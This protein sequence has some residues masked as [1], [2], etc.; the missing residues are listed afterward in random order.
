MILLEMCLL[1]MFSSH[2]EY[3]EMEGMANIYSKLRP[4]FDQRN[5]CQAYDLQPM[6]KQG[7]LSHAALS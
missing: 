4:H 5:M 1:G 2:I 7:T 3:V 6:Y